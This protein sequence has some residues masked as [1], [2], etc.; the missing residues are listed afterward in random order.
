MEVRDRHAAL[1]PV[2][3]ALLPLLP[4]WWYVIA[5]PWPPMSVDDDSAV[6]ELAARRVFHGGQLTGVYSRFG[7][8]HPGPLQLYSMA[9]LYAA[10]GQR[11]AG[12]WLAALLLTTLF[13]GAAAWAAAR[14]LGPRR[15]V[16]AATALALLL[17]R[18]GPGWVAHP[19]GPHAVIVPFALLLVLALG[20]AREGVAWLPAIAFAATY[21]VQTHLGT[22]PAALA[23]VLAAL[24]LAWRAGRRL[25][26]PG[27]ILIAAAVSLVLWAPAL[28]EQARGT[29]S[30]PGNLT[31]LWRFFRTHGASHTFV[32][33]FGPLAHEL[34]SIPVAFATAVVPSTTDHRDVGA[35][36]F[37]LLFVALLP[38]GL[39][40]SRRRRDD[41][42]AALSW[43]ALAA[44]GAALF[45]GLRIVGETFDYLFAWASAVSFA[46]WTALALAATRPFE[47]RGRGR[48]VGATCV[49]VAVLCAVSNSR[50]LTPQQPI[51]VR[52]NEAVRTF[53]DAL[54]SHLAAERIRRP[55]VHLGEGEPWVPAAGALLE[56]ERDGVSWAVDEDWVVMFGKSRRAT[57]AEDG[58]VWF[59]EEP[60]PGLG[61]LAESGKTKLYAAAR[62][63]R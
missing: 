56:L 23:V 4:S 9:P 29:P 15:G 57:G 63:P 35:G 12:L 16:V 28:L 37:A 50:G 47:E 46:G 33:V 10:T 61:L 32:E 41:D 17:A 39:A 8:S 2:L 38:I 20:L 11:S 30:S 3:L 36:L 58:D 22:A 24:A 48:A 6:I 53:H 42:A 27:P 5:K 21:L 26:A 55:L 52:T 40:A 59:T 45:A 13:A 31:L 60:R 44:A 49:V 19:W 14:I 1:G 54:K 43:I 34:G 51:P 62:P 18:M 7:W 25:L